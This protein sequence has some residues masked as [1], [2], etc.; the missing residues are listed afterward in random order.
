[1]LSDLIAC[2]ILYYLFF[3][4]ENHTEIAID[5][6]KPTEEPLDDWEP[7]S[8][9]GVT[10]PYSTPS[11]P[12]TLPS[13]SLNPET[14]IHQVPSIDRLDQIP[15]NYQEYIDF[16]EQNWWDTQYGPIRHPFPSKRRKTK[17]IL[18]RSVKPR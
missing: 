4:L 7:E 2:L 14:I 18:I 10:L 17:T 3:I 6:S 11:P 16:F 13:R 12:P 8:E 5:E 15:K 1:M 9:G